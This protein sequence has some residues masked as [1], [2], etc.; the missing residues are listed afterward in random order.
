MVQNLFLEKTEII[1]IEYILMPI[2]LDSILIHIT[3]LQVCKRH[4]EKRHDL[5]AALPPH[6]TM[7]TS[8]LA[9]ILTYILYNF[10]FYCA[11]Y[12]F[13]EICFTKY[14]RILKS[15]LS[16]KWNSLGFLILTKLS[17]DS[18]SISVST[19]FK[20]LYQILQNLAPPLL[21]I[22]SGIK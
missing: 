1:Y 10:Y 18:I 2:I 12:M 22:N 4:T 6:P 8:L 19:M 15:Y 20:I 16:S 11:L 7:Y 3:L 21:E 5:S 9:S 17:S 13:Y 14:V